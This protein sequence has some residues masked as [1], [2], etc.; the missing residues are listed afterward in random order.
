MARRG[1]SPC[2]H[3]TAGPP[4]AGRK[5]SDTFLRAPVAV[6]RWRTLVASAF[7]LGLAVLGGCVSEADQ[8]LVEG[9][10]PHHDA[11]LSGSWR[12]ADDGASVWFHLGPAGEGG[13]A[14]IVERAAGGE[15]RVSDYTLKTSCFDGHCYA[16]VAWPE[17]APTGY[18]LLRYRLEGEAHLVL[19]PMDNDHLRQ[20]IDSGALAGTFD[21][22][23]LAPSGRISAGREALRVYVAAQGDALFGG[24]ELVLTKVE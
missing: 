2:A 23:G 6:W 4:A 8:P 1:T 12:A 15:P 21:H 22:D 18:V 11:R 20:A 9:A 3:A 13:R 19:E 24:E 16:S 7:A 17:R 10:G 5:G 14:V